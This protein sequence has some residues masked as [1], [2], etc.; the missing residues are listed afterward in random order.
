V[1]IIIPAQEHR[2]NTTTAHIHK[3]GKLE[4]HS[5]NNNNKYNNFK[6]NNNINEVLGQKT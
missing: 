4:L 3:N 5:Q 1:T 2:Y 6:E